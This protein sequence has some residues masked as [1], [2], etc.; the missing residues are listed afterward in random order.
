MDYVFCRVTID[1]PFEQVHTIKHCWFP[2]APVTGDSF[3]TYRD[4]YD[5]S[6]CDEYVGAQWNDLRTADVPQR[7]RGRCGGEG[8][9]KQDGSAGSS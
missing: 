1:I 9:R 7:G 2:A 6:F 5:D 4:T 3:H 8:E